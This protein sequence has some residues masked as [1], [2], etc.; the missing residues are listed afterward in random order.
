LML[1]NGQPKS[2]SEYIQATSRVGRGKVPGLIVS[3][4]NNAKARDRS[5]YETFSTWHNALYRDVESTSVTPFACRAR[6]RALHAALVSLVRH[7]I[8]DMIDNPKIKESNKEQIDA[9]IRYI[10]NRAKII[11]PEE[12]EVQVE[13]DKL[14]NR[15]ILKSPKFY[16]NR[17]A[18]ISLLQDAE[19]AATL[20]AMGRAPGDAWPTLNNMRSVEPASRFRLAERLRDRNSENNNG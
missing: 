1:V 13:L 16:W 17:R 8:P 14:I 3:I 10:T 18:N 20:K 4:L 2:I 5:H 9:V 15:W 11:D 6:D 19:R 7:L 12:A